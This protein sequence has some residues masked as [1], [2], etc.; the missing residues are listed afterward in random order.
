MDGFCIAGLG[1]IFLAQ[2]YIIGRV[3][4]TGV[5]LTAGRNGY[6]E[7]SRKYSNDCFH[8]AEIDCR[9]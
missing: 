6:Y 1:V 7:R 8:S 2:L 4:T 5:A 3:V 9:I